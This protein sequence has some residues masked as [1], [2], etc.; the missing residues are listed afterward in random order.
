LARL[1]AFLFFAAMQ[2]PAPRARAAAGASNSSAGAITLNTTRRSTSD[3]ELGG[4]LA[5]LPRGTTRYTTLEDLLA[6][7]QTTYTVADDPIF[8]GPTQI[9]GVTL[10]ELAK[11]LGAAPESDM[12]VAICDD[13]YRANYPRAYV[14]AHHPLLVLRV[15]GQLPPR[16]PKNPETQGSIGPYLISHPRFAPSF[17]ILSHTD[18]AQVPWGVVRIEFRDESAVFGAIAPRGPH[19]QDT[20]VQAG[21]RIAQ[22]NCFRCH[23]R[24][25]EGGEKSGRP[26]LVLAAWAAA[27]PEYFS[28]YVRAPRKMNRHAEMPGNPSYDQAT[29]GA[30]R[31]YFATFILPEKP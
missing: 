16:W 14:M 19:A 26:W 4:E 6:L 31:D 17:K 5:G 10:E 8:V 22:Q 9:S 29:L 24:G 21:Y 11:L 20:P 18:E 25:G 23:N 2:L 30:I 7:P 13:K 28:G 27:E 3:L 12:V 15:N 1:A